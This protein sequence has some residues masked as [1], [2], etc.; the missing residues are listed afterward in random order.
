MGGDHQLFHYYALATGRAVVGSIR[1]DYVN[2]N[3]STDALERLRRSNVD[4]FCL[5]DGPKVGP[6]IPDEVITAF[7]EAHAPV[8]SPMETDPRRS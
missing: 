3:R 8:P 5:N 7:L 1:Y 2:V 6:G 4:V